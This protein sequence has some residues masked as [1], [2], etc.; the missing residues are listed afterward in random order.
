MVTVRISK[1][2]SIFKKGYLPNWIEEVFTVVKIID[3]NPKQYKLTDYDDNQLDGSFY[4]QEIQVVDKPETF[5][6][7]K[8]LQTRKL[9]GGKKE[10][11]VKW[12]GYPKQFNSWVGED[13]IQQ[14]G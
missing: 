9:R 3:G 14:L 2:K 10:Y 13:A 1:V 6:I 8:V 12:L 4:S 5:R 11:L 7:E